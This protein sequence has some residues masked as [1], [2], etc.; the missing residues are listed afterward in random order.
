M[1]YVNCT[2]R[3]RTNNIVVGKNEGATRCFSHGL[4]LHDADAIVRLL[5]AQLYG[6]CKPAGSVRMRDGKGLFH[7]AALA[8]KEESTKR[9]RLPAKTLSPHVQFVNDIL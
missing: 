7:R 3:V 2:K 6:V 1:E 8:Q 9:K 5:S 4:W